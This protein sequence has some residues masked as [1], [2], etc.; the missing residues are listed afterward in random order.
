VVIQV[1][2]QQV[3]ELANQID[4]FQELV[5]SGA[6]S[7][8]T[9]GTVAEWRALHAKLETAMWRLSLV[10][11][12]PL[13]KQFETL[14]WETAGRLKKQVHWECGGFDLEIGSPEREAVSVALLHAV[15]NAVDHGV[16]TPFERKQAGKVAMGL[17]R[18]EALV[19]GGALRIRI[20]D[21]GRGPDLERIGKRAV[22]LGF[23]PEAS[24]QRLTT[25]ERL[26]LL[27][28]SGFSTRVQATPT[29]GRGIGLDAVYSALHQIGGN[30]QARIAES[31]GFE[32][33]LSVPVD[34]VGAEVFPVTLGSRVF[35]IQTRAC[36]RW[37]AP[38]SE[39]DS[40]AANRL[41]HA[42]G[43]P[44]PAQPRYLRVPDPDG[45]G[46]WLSVD[47]IGAPELRFFR[48]LDPIWRT[49]GP[50]WMQRW[51]DLSGGRALGCRW[52][53]P[54]EGGPSTMAT[55]LLADPEILAHLVGER[56]SAAASPG[57]QTPRR[58]APQ[59]SL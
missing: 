49:T 20:S 1:S 51:M 9:P 34:F 32:L 35:W 26:E 3:E 31:G 12:A 44:V 39:S 57:S 13:A 53:Q 47:S 43:E 2:E 54:V 17:I 4:R 8:W 56:S 27:F 50:L 58:S 45:R 37:T 40:F 33:R 41:A 55:T 18:V 14:A 15:R 29:S 19:L 25:T 30:A 36:E 11:L 46:F 24:V 21:D 48:R 59:S 10:P 28:Q 6:A 38:L 22:E 23:V 7:G 16:E 42:L 5:G 52:L